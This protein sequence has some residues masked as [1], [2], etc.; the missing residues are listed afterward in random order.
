MNVNFY[1]S[2]FNYG[3]GTVIKYGSGSA[4]L[5][6][7][8]IL[9]CLEAS[10]KRVPFFCAGQESVQQPDPEHVPDGA[11]QRRGQARHHAHALRRRAQDHT[12]GNYTQ[13]RVLIVFRI[14]RIHM[15]LGLPDPDSLVRG[16]DPDPSVI[17]QK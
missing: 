5:H 1:D 14:H 13:V 16:M 4:T 2:V 10:H 17:K 11:R 9:K 6:L 12:R 8:N 7:W 3:S 15:F